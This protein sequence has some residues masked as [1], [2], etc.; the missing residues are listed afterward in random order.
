MVVDGLSEKLGVD[1]C[2]L[3]YESQ[4]GKG[5]LAGEPMVLAKPMTYMNRS[6]Q[7]V[8]ALVKGLKLSPAD[9]IIVCDDLDL[10]L[11]TLRIRAKG[12]A[13]GHNGLKSIINALENEEFTRLRLGID[14]SPPG[15]DPADYVLQPFAKQEWPVVQQMICRAQDAIFTLIE[16]GITPAMNQFN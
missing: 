4:L 9:I 6:G 11:G 16:Q 12:G 2:Q 5:E 3:K 13:G 1:L 14:R 10:P 8:G 15:M 7:A